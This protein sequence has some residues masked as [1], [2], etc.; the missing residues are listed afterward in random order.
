MR[1]WLITGSPEGRWITSRLTVVRTIH[2]FLGKPLDHEHE[3]VPDSSLLHSLP[4]A[5]F[6]LLQDQMSLD[7]DTG[8]VDISIQL[9]GSHKMIRQRINISASIAQCF[10]RLPRD[11]EIHPM[12]YLIANEQ[13]AERR[14]LAS[15]LSK[16]LA[17]GILSTVRSDDT[18]NGY[19]PEE[20]RKLNQST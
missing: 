15:I 10:R 20:W 4:H 11:R 3:G 5:I 17:D 1:H 12:D 2:L 14:Q 7:Y 9:P 13:E 18:I 19:E 8:F 16:A 6:N